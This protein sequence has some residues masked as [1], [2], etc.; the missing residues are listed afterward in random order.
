MHG[1]ATQVVEFIDMEHTPKNV[2]IRAV[3]RPESVDTH[4]AKRIEEYRRLL[5]ILG[6]ETCALERP[7]PVES[8]ERE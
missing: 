8:K 3:R 5:T 1:Y 4:R 7:L 2:L 6:L